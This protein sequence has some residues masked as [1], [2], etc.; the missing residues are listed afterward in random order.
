[1]R[2]RALLGVFILPIASGLAAC[3]GDPGAE[4]KY[5]PR[6]SAP[7]GGP[8]G[9]PVPPPEL[10]LSSETVLQAGTYLVSV[11]GSVKGGSITFLDR[12]YPLTQGSQSMYAFIG[13]D[14]DDP[15]GVHTARIDF[16]QGTGSQGR[17]TVPLTVREASWTVDSVTL[18][19]RLQPL[20]DPGV[21]ARELEILAEIYRLQTPA[22]LWSGAWRLPV[23]GV[24]T[25][26][27]GEQRSYNSGPI[28]GHHSGTDLGA[29]LGAPVTVANRGQVA[30]ARQLQL[31]GNMVIVDHGGGVLSGYAHLSSFSVAEGQVVEPGDTVGFVGSTGLSTGAHL[32]WEMSVGGVLVDGLRF[33]DGSNGF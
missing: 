32:H 20:L 6:S 2:R 21:T 26:R 29:A 25:T 4:I 17:M 28:T 1:M 13:V 31:R 16:V 10:L 24:L 8:T 12:T 15:P 27:F 33:V 18:P 23:E 19:A 3:G 22:K 7:R 5:V 11:L 30:M 9:T 14:A